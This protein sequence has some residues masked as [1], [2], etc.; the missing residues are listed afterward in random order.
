M[1][2]DIFVDSI[3]MQGATFTVLVPLGRANG[4]SGKKEE[5]LGVR[6]LVV[7]VPGNE[8]EVCKSYCQSWGIQADYAPGS[9]SAMY[10]LDTASVT[11]KPYQLI[12]VDH[13]MEGIDAHAFRAMALERRLQ[14][15]PK[16]VMLTQ[17]D[18]VGQYE[19]ALLK[20]FSAVLT[21]PLRQSEL[22]DCIMGLTTNLQQMVKDA[23]PRL[24]GFSCALPRSFSKQILVVEDNEIN[25]EVLSMQLKAIGFE[26]IL[27]ENGA[28]AIEL[29]KER[30]FGLILMDCQMPVLNGF[31]TT[32]KIR[33]IET[34]YGYRTP[35]VAMTANSMEG[36][37]E[38]CLDSG[39]DD[40]LG[41][42][43][44]AN[45]LKEI[46]EQWFLVALETDDQ[47]VSQWVSTPLEPELTQ[48][49]SKSW[50]ALEAD[51]GEAAANQFL[52][53][54]IEQTPPLIGQIRRATAEEDEERLR[55]AAHELKGSCYAIH[56]EDLAEIAHR[57]E[58]AAR[59]RQWDNAANEIAELLGHFGEFT[60][61]WSSRVI[62][63]ESESGMMTNPQNIGVFL[64]EDNELTRLGIKAIF[65]KV[66]DINVVGEA[67]D[68]AAAVT[69]I[70]E[71]NP[72]I[73]L[74]DI[75]LPSLNGIEVTRRIKTINPSIKA[76]ML[77]AH[78]SDEDMF[79]A[80]AAGADGYVVK[81]SFDHNRLLLAVRTVASGCCW[82][83]PLIAQR[84]L[85]VASKMSQQVDFSSASLAAT[86][87]PLSP[88]E[89]TLLRR[90]AGGQP[91]CEDGVCR[92]GP[93][94]LANLNRFAKH[95]ATIR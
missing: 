63:A 30:R 95:Q 85:S 22:F 36:D 24:D 18:E 92:V 46:I 91:E 5:L 72:D 81:H 64:V 41:K 27:A 26:P 42:P 89:E 10:F 14:P 15:T 52:N 1:E 23:I 7:G 57:I 61:E 38:A 19:E 76:L 12:L 55:E 17:L 59:Q 93:T 84:V 67:M 29:L 58:V 35:I 45:K 3:H 71:T 51:F 43:V 66:A 44:T 78:D 68:G 88:G 83:D 90:V 82:L 37:R 49:S 54:F 16:F 4:A 73:V 25:Q 62:S 21:K 39:M 75:G 48:M 20:G 80:F 2:G 31:E 53:L 74:L 94:F 87:Q 77:T 65:A 28:K 32:K 13:S 70:L 79:A 33:L 47:M 6:L 8:F 34:S 50:S 69:S 11:R 60:K 40:Y 56:C 86:V 9:Q